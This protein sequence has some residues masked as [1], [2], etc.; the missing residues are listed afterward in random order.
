VPFNVDPGAEFVVG[1][2]TF[3]G[4]QN[5]PSDEVATEVAI[6]VGSPFN[7]AEVDQARERLL[8]L[9]RRHGFASVTVSSGG[10]VRE[11]EPR[12]DVTFQVREGARQTI[13]DIVVAGNAGIDADVITGAL[14]LT[15]GEPLEPEELVRA[16]T[17]IYNTGL[18]RRVD[19]TTQAMDRKDE[20][21]QPMRIRV[22]VDAWP[23]FRLRYGFQA[24]EQRPENDP[25]GRELEPGLIADIA[26]RTLFGR[27]IGLDGSVQYQRRQNSERALVSVPTL[28]SLPILSSLVLQHQHQESAVSSFVTNSNNVSWEQQLRASHLTLLYSYQFGRNHTF[29]TVRELGSGLNLDISVRIARLNGTSVWDTRNNQ[30]DATRGTLVSSTVEW[31]PESLGSQFR[32]LKYVGQAYRFQNVHGIVLASAA[33]LGLARALGGQDFLISERFFAGGSRTVRG[34]AED[35]L[36]PRDI[37]GDPSGGEAM[38]IF[39]QEARVPLYKQLGGVAFIDAGNIFGHPNEIRLNQLTGSIG[40]GLRLNTPFA[41]LRVDYGKVVWPGLPK[42]GT[43]TDRWFFGIGQAF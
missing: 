30:L 20:Q 19:V 15:T 3:E 29:D 38:L 40:V 41:L 2:V 37:F 33:R 12:V 6:P 25:T 23:A 35:S 14:K 10:A 42:T 43:L 28:W 22:T 8:A 32:F 24:A 36:G 27:A 34:V 13:E 1:S 4:R 9:Y 5:V 21:T 39:N 16:R 31:A 18:F 11:T 26:R 17:R 7:P